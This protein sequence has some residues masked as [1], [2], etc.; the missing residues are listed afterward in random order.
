MSEGVFIGLVVLGSVVF[1]ALTMLLL[2]RLREKF[3]KPRRVI[4]APSKKPQTPTV[5][6]LGEP[7]DVRELRVIRAL[8]GEPR[9]RYLETYKVKRYGAAL[10]AVLKKGWVRRVDKR[11]YMTSKGA[12]FCRAYL[13]EQMDVWQL[14]DPVSA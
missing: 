5:T 13:R 8:F 4:S 11:Y 6:V 10:N 3:R 9:G 7:V 14:A 1:G 2:A 12:E